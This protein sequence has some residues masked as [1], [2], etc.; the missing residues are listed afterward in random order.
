LVERPIS[1]HDSDQS[2]YPGPMNASYPSTTVMGAAPLPPV[3]SANMAPTPIIHPDLRNVV[4]GMPPA[5]KAARPQP[6]KAFACTACA[7]GFAR[8]SDL[9]RH[10]KH[11]FATLC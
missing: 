2:R 5:Q 10:G 7:K 1:A 11:Q 4:P 6:A 8:R 3:P 9:A